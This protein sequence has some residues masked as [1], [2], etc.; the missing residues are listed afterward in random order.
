MNKNICSVTGLE[1]PEGKPWF[2]VV[3][4]E[5]IPGTAFGT[6]YGMF[7]TK[8]KAMELQLKLGIR[9]TTEIKEF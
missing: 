4:R 6:M 5:N 8:K 1:I 2:N 7:E 9:A 3:S